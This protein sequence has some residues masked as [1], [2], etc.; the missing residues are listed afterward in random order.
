MNINLDTLVE[1]VEN[2]FVL[3][4]QDNVQNIYKTATKLRINK[5][6]GGDMT[7]LLNEVRGIKC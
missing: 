1:M 4:E 5:S 7:Q 2:Q 6:R 3:S